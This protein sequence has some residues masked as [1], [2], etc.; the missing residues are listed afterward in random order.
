MINQIIKINEKLYTV[1]KLIAK[2]KGGYTYLAKSDADEVV[3]K[4]IHYE[5][6]DYY[7]F[8]ENKL[9][10][11]LR[12]YETLSKLGLPVPKLLHFCQEEQFL[13]KEYINGDTLA[14]IAADNRITD[15]HITQI[16]DMCRVLYQNQLNI[17]YFPT[18]FIERQ[19]LLY[20]VDY[21]CSEY[22][23]EWNFEN[24]GIWF[25]ANQKGMSSFLAD[26]NHKSII[27]DGKPIKRGLE[28]IVER[29]LLRYNYSEY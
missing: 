2:G 18:N 23:N 13:V 7:Q 9:N 8:E 26:G 20:Y 10:S 27:E 21:E 3:V 14:K 4:Q 17:D 28:S 15:K 19:G 5:P 11:E 22:S 24:W 16:F 12:D 29:W 25:L 6:C 1:T